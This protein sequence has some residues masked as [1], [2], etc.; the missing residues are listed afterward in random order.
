MK[1]FLALLLAL[2]MALSLVACG[3]GDTSSE[4]A[5]AT[6]DKGIVEGS[7]KSAS[8]ETDKDVYIDFWGV[9]ANDNYRVR[10]LWP[11]FLR[12]G[13]REAGWR[14]CDQGAARH[15]PGGGAGYRPLLSSGR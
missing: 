13:F 12:R 2:C 8:G 1:K 11:G 3:G 5:P 14:R 10:V 9:W 4:E 6:D 15:L 7:N